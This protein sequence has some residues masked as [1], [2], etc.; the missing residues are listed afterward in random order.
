LWRGAT[1]LVLAISLLGI[2]GIR[3]FFLKVVDHS[4]F[5]R[6]ALV[7]GTGK[8]SNYIKKLEGQTLLMGVDV[9]G[10]V[11]V[12]EDRN[13]DPDVIQYDRPLREIVMEG[14]V[15]EIVLAID[16]RRKGMPVTDLLDC[17]MDG[18]SV[19]DL[20]TFFERET[21]KIKLDLMNPSWLFLSDGFRVS[22]VRFMV[23]RTFDIFV[24]LV[25]L[26]VFF[27]VMVLVAAAV[28]FES[29]GMESVIYK[30]VRVGEDNKNF[31]IYK[32][33]SMRANAEV[34]GIAR[35]AEKNDRRVTRVGNIIRKIRLDELPQIFNILKGDMSF[36][37]P[38]PE[39]PEFVGELEKDHSYYRERHRV[40]PGLTG[41]AQVCYQYGDSLEDAYE[42]LEYDL[43]YVKNYSIFLDLLIIVQTIRV[44]LSGQ[45]AH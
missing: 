34:D 10:Y 33:R 6:R 1:L 2:V 11:S 41:W 5:K 12:G 20:L 23:K 35:W 18:V 9:V 28:W 19:V 29:R 14:R 45:G 36:V 26:P 16:D 37:G 7:L 39:R 21:G 42:K 40:K 44:V 32:F 30:Q 8:R 13:D 3:A 24:C 25:L 27:P 15:D 31:T 17:K 4:I 38:R 22:T 43:Y